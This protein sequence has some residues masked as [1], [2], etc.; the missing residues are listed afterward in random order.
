[1]S[2]YAKSHIARQGTFFLGNWKRKYVIAVILL[3][4]LLYPNISLL[5]ADDYSNTDFIVRD[6]VIST[7][8]G[9][10]TSATFEYF[11]SNGQTVAGENTS[12]N[13]IQRAGFLYFPAV[14]TAV[15]STPGGGGG[16]SSN[17]SGGSISSYPLPI[18]PEQKKQAIAA[19]DFSKDG[20]CDIADFSI[21]LYYFGKT[22][23]QIAPY[24]L[25]HDG[26]VDL[27]DFSILLYYWSL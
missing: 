25:N 23:P 16:S 5:K 15:V 18:T 19:C 8:G 17:V 12:T 20:I 6:P 13:F 14:T 22:G 9:R 3:L 21:L 1:M 26:K 27:I 10:S 2:S 24:D 11:S 4:F 7:G